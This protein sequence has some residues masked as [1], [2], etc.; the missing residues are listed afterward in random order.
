LT[1]RS[2]IIGVA[3]S[4]LLLTVVLSA[5]GGALPAQQWPGLTVAGGTV[6]VI[7]G[8]PQQVYLLDAETGVQKGVYMPQGQHKGLVYWS[9]VTVSDDDLAKS[10]S[11]GPLA[12]VGFSEPQAKIYGLFAFDATTG[13]EQWSIPAQDLI[14]A[15]PVYSKGVV[16]YGSSDGQVYAIDVKTR[17]VKTGWPFRAKEAIW[18]APLVA[19]SQVYVASMDHHVY[20]LDAETGKLVWDFEAK[21]AMAVQPVLDAARG[22]LYVGDFDARVYAIEASS[23]KAVSGFDFRAD[24]WIWSEALL[25]GDRLYVSSLD[26]NLYALDPAN[27][28]V[29]SP[30]PF[31]AGN[32]L[33]AAPAQSGEVI[34]AA[35]EAGKL[36]AVNTTNAQPK[37]QWPSGVPTAAIYTTPVVVDGTV[38]VVLMNGQVVALQADNGVQRWTFTPP[39]IG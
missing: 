38:Y 3:S 11:E 19:D 22:V 26:G 36:T 20:C 31:D 14:L 39:Q 10:T 2:R 4:L 35:S 1:Q 25:A 16:Y 23:G 5:C 34:L 21:G 30:Y 33:R 9:P 17:M 12:F 29:V 15:A 32:P 13:L 7:S 28:A 18:G 8:S 37:W 6:Y 24:N 27:G